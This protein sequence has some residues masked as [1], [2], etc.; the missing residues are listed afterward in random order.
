MKPLNEEEQQYLLKY[1]RGVIEENPIFKGHDV[2]IQ[3]GFVY[4]HNLVIVKETQIFETIA[5]SITHNVYRLYFI[6]DDGEVIC[7][8]SDQ[9]YMLLKNV[10]PAV[11][12][13]ILSNFYED[14]CYP[15][16]KDIISIEPHTIPP[17]LLV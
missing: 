4:V 16:E 2:N 12:R 8:A 7:K 14:E 1:L 3:D 15:E 11:L 5:E 13:N 9:G 17:K 6:D 10:V